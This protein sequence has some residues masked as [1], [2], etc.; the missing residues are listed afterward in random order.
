MRR[1]ATPGLKY[2]TRADGT[3]AAIWCAPPGAIRAGFTPRTLDMSGCPVD[4]LPARCERLWAEALAFTGRQVDPLGYDGR[5]GSLLR[6]YELHPDS[7]LKK[8]KSTSLHTYSIYLGR[9]AKAYGARRIDSVTGL[10]VLRWAKD[11][12]GEEGHVAAASMALAVLKA[13]LS[14]GQVCGF[15]PAIQKRSRSK[16]MIAT[17]WFR[18]RGLQRQGRSTETRRKT[19]RIIGTHRNY[20]N[21][22]LQNQRLS[23]HSC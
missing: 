9:L 16:F 15:K 7:P 5:L 13:A 3:R 18:R 22:R 12:R 11:W 8:L 6:I 23:M 10:D 14:F 2:R 4:D 17:F 19:E 20:R 21:R 1:S